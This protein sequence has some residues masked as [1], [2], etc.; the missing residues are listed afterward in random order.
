MDK[1]V[2]YDYFNDKQKLDNLDDKNENIYI[3]P[4]KRGEI[5]YIFKLMYILYI[6]NLFNKYINGYPN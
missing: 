2:N 5:A 6:I 1:F 4:Y 3:I